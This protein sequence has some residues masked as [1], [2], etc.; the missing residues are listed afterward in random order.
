MKCIKCV[1]KIDKA[2]VICCNE[3]EYIRYNTEAVASCSST[4]TEDNIFQ[5]ENCC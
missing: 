4:C 5:T 3:G 1:G 2:G